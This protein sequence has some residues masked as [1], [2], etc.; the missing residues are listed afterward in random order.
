MPSRRDFHS[1]AGFNFME[2]M[3]KTGSRILSAH[4]EPEMVR[5]ANESG[6]SRA[7]SEARPPKTEFRLS[8]ARE[9]T[10]M[11]GRALALAVLGLGHRRT[12]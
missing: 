5:L 10:S 1:G 12:H 7:V 8:A 11:P 6:I 2:V 3:N 4:R 9:A